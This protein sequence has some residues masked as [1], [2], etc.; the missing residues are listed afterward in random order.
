MRRVC[1]ILLL[2]PILLFPITRGDI[3]AVA[4]RYAN[5]SWRVNTPNHRYTIYTVPGYN[6]IGEAYSFGDKATIATFDSEIAEGK[7][8]RNW[9]ANFNDSTQAIYTDIDCSGFVTRS[10]E[11][12]EYLVNYTNANGLSNYTVTISGE[13]KPGDIWWSSEHV[14]LQSETPGM[15]YE[16]NPTS[17]HLLGQRVQFWNREPLGFNGYFKRSIFPQFSQESPANG[18]VVE[19]AQ[20]KDISVTIAA[21]GNIASD[22]VSMGIN[23]KQVS[24]L[25]LE[26]PTDTTWKVRAPNFDVSEGRAFNV[27]VN[28]RNDVAGRWGDKYEK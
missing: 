9:E 7:I 6:V 17:Y 18:E 21:K 2:I 15:V 22:G 12:S 25:I 20:T 10:L 5:F 11:F 1:L 13:P 26:H 8:P 23:G 24:N 16:A 27:V 14:F 3:I 19:H 4:S 28:A